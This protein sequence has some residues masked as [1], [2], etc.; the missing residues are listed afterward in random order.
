MRYWNDTGTAYEIARTRVNVG[1]GQVNRG[2]Y[3]F[4]V[5]NGGGLRQWLDV[6]YGGNV[7]FNEGGHDSD[8]RVES[9]SNA[10]MLCVDASA[11][12]VGIGTVPSAGYVYPP[13]CTLLVA[14]KLAGDSGKARV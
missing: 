12:N 8:F 14:V 11:N 13:Q 10:N 3:Q 9:D 4:S 5:N 6:D 1:A 7:T 2:E